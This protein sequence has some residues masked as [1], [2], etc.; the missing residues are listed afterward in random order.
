MATLGAQANNLQSQ[1]DDLRDMLEQEY[2]QGPCGDPATCPSVECKSC[3]A[4]KCK[5]TAAEGTAE[6][7][8][9]EKLR[10][11]CE[12][13]CMQFEIACAFKNFDQKADQ[14]FNILSTVLKNM[15]EMESGIVRNLLG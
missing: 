6:R 10:A 5:I 13:A 3:C 12:L 4:W 9:Q 1:I 11:E 7:S 8:A 14:L 2:G 15:K